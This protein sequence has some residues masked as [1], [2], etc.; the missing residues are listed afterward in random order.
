MASLLD[1]RKEKINNLVE[2]FNAFQALLDKANRALE[3]YQ[4]LLA[5]VSELLK[6][7][8]KSIEENGKEKD[9]AIAALTSTAKGNHC[10]YYFALLNHI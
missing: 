7:V 2:S 9:A 10:V 5:N 3:F 4:K 6:K 8:R 1:S